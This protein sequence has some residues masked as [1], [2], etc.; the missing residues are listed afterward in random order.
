MRE[1]RS[2]EGKMGT[3]PHDG[4]DGE[5]GLILGADEGTLRGEEPRGGAVREKGDHGV[6]LLLQVLSSRRLGR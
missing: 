1:A 3:R 2:A 4:D 6:V 5:A